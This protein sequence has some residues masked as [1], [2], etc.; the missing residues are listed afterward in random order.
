[1]ILPQGA[2]RFVERGTRR[3]WQNRHTVDRSYHRATAKRIR[4]PRAVPALATALW[5]LVVASRAFSQSASEARPGQNVVEMVDR[6]GDASLLADS[7]LD[8]LRAAL[9]RFGISIDS[10][11]LVF[12]KTSL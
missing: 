8:T 6:E 4:A 2:S 3:P 11:L 12:S 5:L 1:M 10:Q 9:R 7:P